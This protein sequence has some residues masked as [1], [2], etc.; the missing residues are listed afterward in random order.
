MTHNKLNSEFDKEE[1]SG[2]DFKLIYHLYHFVRP[3]KKHFIIALSIIFLSSLQAIIGARLLGA[4]IDLGLMQKSVQQSLWY[5]F[6][7]LLFEA[8]SMACNYFGR[9]KL[10][11]A[12]SQFILHLRSEMFLKLEKLPLSYYDQTPQ[13]KIVTRLTSDLEGLEEFFNASLGNMLWALV[14]TILAMVAMIQAKVSL[15]LVLLISLTPCIILV[16]KTRFLLRDSNRRV[17]KSSSAINAK[18]SEFV[19]GL[20]VIRLFGLEKWSIREFSQTIQN[21]LTLQL[22]GNLIFAWNMPLVISFATFPLLGLVWFGGKGVLAGTITF[23][24]FV[25]FIR[26]FEKFFNPLIS[27]ARD[28]HLVQQALTSFERVFSFLNLPEE[29]IEHSTNPIKAP[30]FKG[31][32][33]FKNVSMTYESL[34]SHLFHKDQYHLVLNDVSFQIKAGQKVGLVG[35]TGSGKS[36][37]LA[38][39]SKLYPFQWGDIFIDQI[40]IKDINR[41]F[42]R[43]Q[44]ATVSQET[45]LFEGTLLQNLSTYASMQFDYTDFDYFL[46]AF[47]TGLFQTLEGI[48]D[49]TLATASNWQQFLNKPIKDQGANLSIGEKQLVSITRANLA[50]PSVLILDEA[51]ANIDHRCEERIFKALKKM[52][53]DRTTIMIAHRLETLKDCDLIITF[54]EGRVASIG[55]YIDLMEK[56]S[57]QSA[58]SFL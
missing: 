13:G 18:M 41:S 14:T 27:V 21:Y 10:A 25:S 39:L 38:L 9:K 33:E 3:Y 2:E 49:F 29:K 55:S 57:I 53:Q 4:F 50:R 40:N 51:T 5:G 8:G 46:A 37:T 11:D 19:S 54:H 31:E 17:S 26:Y 48:E 58:S 22:R 20:D 45:I 47:E 52:G 12:T 32:I 1:F 30:K 15:S 56:K 35:K 28:L 42:L 6:L 43:S 7:V 24:L 16:A 36:S 34:S 44:I 23:G